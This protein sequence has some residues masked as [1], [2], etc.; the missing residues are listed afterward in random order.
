MKTDGVVF[1][2]KQLQQMLVDEMRQGGDGGF[3][4]SLR[5]V[6]N[7]A[8]LP[9]IVGRSMAMPDIHSGYG[10]AIGNVAATDMDDP[11]AVVSPGGVGFDINC[12]VR[13]LRTNLLHADLK[14]KQ[15]SHLADCLF[16]A[17]PVGVGTKGMAIST[18]EL[19]HIMQTGLGFMVERGLAWPEDVER[20]E[21]RGCLNF[22]KPQFISQRAKLR[23]L[24]QCGSLGSGNH[25]CEI[26]VV[27]EIFHEKAAEAMGLKKGIIVIMIHSG[28][29]GLGHQVCTDHLQTISRAG[30]K[31]GVQVNDRQLAAVRIQSDEGQRY[32]GAMAAAA[33]FAFCNRAIMSD[34]V[35]RTFA[36]FF[37]KSARDLDMHLIYDVCHNIA[38]IEEHSVEGVKR[39]LLV[40]RKGATRCFPPE[41][42]DLPA[43]YSSVGQPV[44]I[45]GSMGTESWIL[46]GTAKSM[47]LTFGSTCHGAG[48]AMSRTE[49]A[50]LLTPK[51]VLS[52]LADQ[53]IAIR[54]VK[55]GLVAEEAPESYKDVSAVVDTCVA[56]G[57]S[58]KVARL[59]PIAVIKG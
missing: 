57:I 44:I 20:C 50:K 14:P 25:Y 9:G 7:V 47:E 52:S 33:N 28:S 40:H 17:L 30:T 42:P 54:V 4:P 43:C 32:L 5:Q 22:A 56:A 45:G 37:D 3:I 12:G 6:A 21:E 10:F 31:Q 41:H 36:S 58:Q 53:G 19:E 23:G 18:T 16:D 34:I 1:A 27:D 13:L 35:R 59:K 55:K 26:Q 39:R 51:Q 2:N 11:N 38:K 29:R 8:A 15:I 46:V 24:P 49:A 48:R